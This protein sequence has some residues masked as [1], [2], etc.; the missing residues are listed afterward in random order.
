MTF[1]LRRFYFLGLLILSLALAAC[2]QDEPQET[3][4]LPT[5]IPPTNT[6]EPTATNTATPEPTA[7]NT[8]TPEP[9]AT[10]TATPEPTATNTATPEPTDTPEPTATAT[11]TPA[12]TAVPVTA[13]AVSASP[14][15]SG[16]NGGGEGEGSEDETPDSI[17]L[18]YI[19]N[20]SD[21]LGTFPVQ[22]FDADAIRSD[23]YGMQQALNTMRSNLDGAKA[24]DAAAC[25]A[26]VQGYNNIL[27]GTRFFDEVPANWQDIDSLYVLLFIYSLDRTR[28]AY[29]SCA[30]SGRI[31]D[32]NYS[33]AYTTINDT[34]EVLNPTVQSAASR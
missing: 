27:Y 5:A 3:A 21:I 30:N 19:S 8:A 4:V 22:P 18:Y 6:A 1:S 12:P 26:Y 11:N 10:S 29:L 23:L 24:G 25:A 13:T 7:T 16:D 32:F 34:L 17:T 2:G 9:T 20:P 28:P 33:L 31:D 15:P 14:T